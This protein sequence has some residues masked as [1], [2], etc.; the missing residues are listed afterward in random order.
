MD[1]SFSL[2]RSTTLFV[3]GKRSKSEVTGVG[4]MARS[5]SS[6]PNTSVIDQVLKTI[7]FIV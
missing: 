1:L 3:K 7:R 5:S 6:R 2:R 4:T